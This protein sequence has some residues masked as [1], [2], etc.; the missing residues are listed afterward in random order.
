[1]NE[2]QRYEDAEGQ[3]TFLKS[4]MSDSIHTTFCKRQNCSENR[5]V[6]TRGWNGGECDTKGQQESFLK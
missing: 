6:V 5:L 3:K 1:M 4:Y 2:S